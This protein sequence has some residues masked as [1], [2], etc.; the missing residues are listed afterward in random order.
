LLIIND[1]NAHGSRAVPTAASGGEGELAPVSALAALD[2]DGDG[3][4]APK[5]ALAVIN[6]LN[7]LARLSA[8][9]GGEGEGATGDDDA[10]LVVAADG[11]DGD[12]LAL[13]AADVAGASRRRR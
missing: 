5:D 1:L 13:L 7:A 2:V 4:I 9:S 10:A 11:P 3:Y 12:I 6:A 8:G